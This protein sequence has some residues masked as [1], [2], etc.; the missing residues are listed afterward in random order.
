MTVSTAIRIVLHFAEVVHFTH[1][2]C[3][4]LMPA[5]DQ[6]AFYS[7]RYGMAIYGFPPLKLLPSFPVRSGYEQKCNSIRINCFDMRYDDNER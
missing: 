6:R 4:A 2:T 7:C 5:R 1:T 3:F